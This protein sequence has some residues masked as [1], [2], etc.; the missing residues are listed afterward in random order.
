MNGVALKSFVTSEDFP[1]ED[2]AY[3]DAEKAIRLI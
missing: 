1:S 2:E 3:T